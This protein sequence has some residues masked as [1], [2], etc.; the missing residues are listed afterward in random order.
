MEEGGENS[1]A[2]LLGLMLDQLPVV[3]FAIDREG[4]IRIARGK[5]AVR[6]RDD[7]VGQSA[8][9][10]FKDLPQ[11]VSNVRRALSGEAFAI[12]GET[13]EKWW[14]TRYMPMRGPGGELTGVIGVTMDATARKR[15]E[16]ELKKANVRLRELDALKAQFVANVSHE[17]RTPLAIILGLT[18]RMRA[19]EP[20]DGAHARDLGSVEHS[21]RLLLKH[22]NDLLDVAKLDAGR[23]HPDYARVDLARL[24]ALAA[25]PFD[26]LAA[27]RGLT[28]SIEV[29]ASLPAEVDPDQV[30]RILLNLLSNA[31][32]LT[33]RGGV[34]RC[35]LA[36]R[37]ERATLSVSDSGPGVPPSRRKAIFE[38]F[39]QVERGDERRFGGTGLG[40]SI[41]HDYVELH[42]GEIAVEDAPEGGARFVVTL[43]LAAPAGLEVRRASDASPP[44]EA[45]REAVATL[46]RPDDAGPEGPG[47]DPP[48]S[49][50]ASSSDGRPRV[51]VVEDDPEMRRFMVG[52]LAAE[53]SVD[54]AGDGEHALAIARTRRPAAVVTDLMMP[55]MDG[56]RL[57][58]AFREDPALADTP[59][60]VLTARADDDLRVRLLRDG[61]HDYI[62]KPFGADELL[63]RVAHAASLKRARDVMARELQSTSRNVGELSAQLVEQNR[64][65]R[66]ALDAI[67]SARAEADR[68]GEAADAFLRMLADEVSAPAAAVQREAEAAARVDAHDEGRLAVARVAAAAN[69]LVDVVNALVGYADVKSGRAAVAGARGRG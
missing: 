26:V 56:E 38:R 29:P 65:L 59:V 69:R 12:E 10:L 18:G 23:V 3:L 62:L 67:R 30:Q 33:P 13:D 41:V 55:R 36:A 60:I 48:P 27:E 46:R 37:G 31:F 25:S 47:A 43:P 20:E 66:H 8:F 4:I 6:L 50:V 51:L 53:F 14:E 44:G 40:L 58:R 68:S 15:A 24:V 28:L 39:V 17:L 52:T 1:T 19:A 9:E 16:E 57:V 64:N 34:V 5:G 35:V 63:A 45:R 42:G 11:V 2:D 21:A 54:E 32:K 22:V 7:A 61:A 49:S